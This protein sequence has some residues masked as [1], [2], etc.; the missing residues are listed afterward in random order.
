MT[1]GGLLVERLRAPFGTAPGLDDISFSVSPGERLALVGSSGAGKTTLLRAVAGLGPGTAAR[2][3]V[4]GNEVGGLPAERRGVVYLHQT[5]LLFPHLTVAENVAFPLRVR[6]VAPA[7]VAT[8][9]RQ[10]LDALQLGGLG[11]RRTQALSGGQRHRAAL[12]RAIVARPPVLLLDEPFASLDPALRHE[13]REAVRVVQE[14]YRPALVL[15]THD[16]DEAGAVADR[17]GVLLDGRLVQVAPPRELFR[18]PASAAVARFLR[19]PNLVPGTVRGDGCFDS[20]LGPLPLG[21]GA[22]VGPALAFF[23][24]DAVRIAERGAISGRIVELRYRV[25]QTTAVVAV[26]DV[27]LE[28]TL[29][30]AG[31]PAAGA[32]VRLT[33]SSEAVS[34]FPVA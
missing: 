26:G 5:P 18:R 27:R 25:Q 19:L 22:E 7:Q 16:L 11:Q 4:A 15:V 33:L 14:A 17:I 28:A 20:V 13:V 23:G 9:V 31:E 3:E 32:E 21:P 12:A 1:R 8:A 10:V 34:V 30:G 2:I 6:R 24:A 29:D